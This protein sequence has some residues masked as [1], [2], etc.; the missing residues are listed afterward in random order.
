MRGDDAGGGCV[1][2]SIRTVQVAPS[3][4]N[5]PTKLA[6]ST[7]SDDCP[8]LHTGDPVRRGL[9]C[10]RLCAGAGMGA[11][12]WRNTKILAKKNF[13]I[14]REQ[15]CSLACNCVSWTRLLPF[16]PAGR[17]RD[18]DAPRV[19]AARQCP[20]AVIWELFFPVGII[21]LFAYLKTLDPDSVT[22]PPGWQRR[23]EDTN[24]F[25]PVPFT[26]GSAVSSTSASNFMSSILLPLHLRPKYKLALAA[27]SAAGAP[28]PSFTA[29][30]RS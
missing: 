19:S 1:E 29:I 23:G 22:L 2:M 5:P 25:T 7:Y 20:C 14:K 15:Y 16:A 8:V 6:P 11:S 18:P 30:L 4:S 27:Q 28:K 13:A 3:E 12:A 9:L 21:A 17:N 24:A 10:P 26:Y